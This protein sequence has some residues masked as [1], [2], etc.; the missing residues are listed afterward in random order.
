ML[1]IT[2]GYILSFLLSSTVSVPCCTT[3]LRP[4][5]KRLALNAILHLDF[6]TIVR[7]G[8]SKKGGAPSTAATLPGF[9]SSDTQIC[10]EF[11]DAENLL[12]IYSES[13]NFDINSTRD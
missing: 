1:V 8:R 6:G 10:P 7:K 13:T 5:A 4:A 9:C 2:G 3:M 11:S 12:G